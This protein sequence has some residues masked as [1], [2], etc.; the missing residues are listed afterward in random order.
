MRTPLRKHI[1]TVDVRLMFD[2]PDELMDAL[3]T[4]ISRAVED[5]QDIVIACGNKH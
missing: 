3:I 1:G 4:K 5:W 2:V